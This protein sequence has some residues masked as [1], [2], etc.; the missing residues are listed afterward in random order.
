MDGIKNSVQS[1]YVL[2]GPA[3]ISS[4]AETNLGKYGTVTRIYGSD[5]YATCILVNEKFADVLTGDSM[6]LACGT[7]YPDALAGSVLAAKLRSPLML[8]GKTLTDG[9]RTYVRS[10]H[11]AHVYAFG[12]TF[13]LSDEVFDEVK[14]AA[15]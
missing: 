3:I 10:R 2:A 4:N 9:Q 6:C 12:G 15:K 8:V 1:V 11:P 13:V 14:Q 5:R 7:N